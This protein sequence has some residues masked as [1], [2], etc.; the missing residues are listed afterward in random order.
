MPRAAFRH[1]PVVCL[2]ATVVAVAG[3]APSPMRAAVKAG[4]SA[5]AATGT[6]ASGQPSAAASESESDDAQ[7]KTSRLTVS[8]DFNR[9]GIADRAEVT[10]PAGDHA[11][12]GLLTVS[13][14]QAD[15]TLKQVSSIPMP[16]NKPQDMVASDFNQDGMPDLIVGDDDGTLMLFL[17]DGTGKM[18]FGGNIAHLSSVVSIVVADFNRDGIPDVAVSDWRASSV[19]ILLGAGKGSLRSGGWSFPLR[20]GGTTPHLAVADFNGDGI[21]DLAVVYDDDQED[22]FDVMLGNGNGTFNLAPSLGLV[23][24][25]NAHCVT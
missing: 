13:L 2:V 11:G 7:K 20:M 21:P 10:L 8:G 4:A 6:K 12:P 17:G 5:A 24:D 1:R 9:D 18:V 15:G 3:F 14:G 25:A 22:T 19:T 16:G 23:R